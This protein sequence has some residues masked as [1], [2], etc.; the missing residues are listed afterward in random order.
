MSSTRTKPFAAATAKQSSVANVSQRQPL[1]A[2][3]LLTTAAAKA[4]LARRAAT[5]PAALAHASPLPG[6][7]TGQHPTA[8]ICWRCGRRERERATI[9]SPHPSLAA[10]PDPACA[11]SGKHAGPCGACWTCRR[12]K[13]GIEYMFAGPWPT[14]GTAAAKGRRR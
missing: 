12:A 8:C 7:P 6:H 4:A 10:I 14:R 5:G 9:N 11:S 2:L 1:S 13:D 3:G